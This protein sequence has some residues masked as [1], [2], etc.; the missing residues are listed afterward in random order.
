M[1]GGLVPLSVIALEAGAD[2]VFPGILSTIDSWY[3]MVYSHLGLLL[4]AVLAPAA[5]A[6]DDIFA[7]QHDPLGRHLD[8]EIKPYDR[9]HRDLGRLRAQHIP[10]G[11]L[12]YL[13]LA[14]V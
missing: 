14:Q 5:I 1:F 12:D 13:G 9:W 11:C 6:F 10:I 7:S 3:D 2:Q 4:A 8:I